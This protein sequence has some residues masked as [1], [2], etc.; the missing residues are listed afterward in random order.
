VGL[1]VFGLATAIRAFRD[2][3]VIMI[4][5]WA[6][7]RN[8]QDYTELLQERDAL[9]AQ[10][11]TLNDE[12]QRLRQNDSGTAD[13]RIHELA[14]SLLWNYYQSGEKFTWA[15]VNER[16][17]AGPVKI[18]RA[19]WDVITDFFRAAKVIDG[20]GGVKVDNFQ[21]AW[22]EFLKVHMNCT[23]RRMVSKRLIK[24]LPPAK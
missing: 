17:Q 14:M 12:I 19:V 2:E 6:E 13:G 10:V 24:A 20:N 22:A 4:H 11:L 23:S 15:A 21:E 5:A 16:N 9:Q 1:L 3:I 7:R 18:S 8:R